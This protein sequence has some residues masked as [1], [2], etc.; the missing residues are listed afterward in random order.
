MKAEARTYIE[1]LLSIGTEPL[2]PHP[3]FSPELLE[4]QVLGPELFGMLRQ[5]N[6]FYAFESALHVF[7]IGSPDSMSLEEWNS[8]S[9][10]RDCYG[11]LA[12]GL[13]FFAEDVFQDQFCLSAEGVLRFESECGRTSAVAPSV[14]E[15]A[16]KVLDGYRQETG[17][18]LASK[19]QS[20]NGPLSMGKRLM[21]KIPFFLGGG[22]SLDNLWVGEAVEGMRF[23]GD[24]A[25]QTKDL[26]DGAQIR[27]VVGKKPE[28]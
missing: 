15:W 9:L 26:P 1:K 3:S 8:P 24:L 20:E 17:W 2:G 12:Q 13:L 25:L 28:Q 10:W 19:W 11:D 5:K 18:P 21:P 16:R 14:E 7:P 6:G 22:Y 4:P 27:L 23:K